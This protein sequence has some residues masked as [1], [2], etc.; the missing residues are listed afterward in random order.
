MCR[1]WWK[2]GRALKHED[3]AQAAAKRKQ[4]LASHPSFI[5]N[6]QEEKSSAEGG[7]NKSADEA[8]SGDPESGEQEVNA[9]SPKV[10][11]EVVEWDPETKS[12]Q[13]K[14]AVSSD[15]LDPWTVRTASK[16]VLLMLMCNLFSL[17]FCAF[18][19]LYIDAG[20]TCRRHSGAWMLKRSKQSSIV[21]I[22]VLLLWVKFALT[23]TN[24]TT[25]GRRC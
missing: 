9:Q 21:R 11:S 1:V 24:M 13:A 5:V 8:K 16:A 20:H 23:S 25:M 10:G 17:W 19:T 22:G 3:Q 18:A 15:E 2:V 7:D 6:T 14:P 12:L 4:E